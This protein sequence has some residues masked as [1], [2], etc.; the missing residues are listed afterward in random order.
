MAVGLKVYVEPLPQGIWVD[1]TGAEAFDEMY[2]R[3]HRDLVALCRRLLCGR[4]DPEAVAQEAFLRAWLSLDRYSTAR[5][6]WPWLATIARRL[7]IDHR[8]RLQREDTHAETGALDALPPTMSSPEEAIE[9]G[10]ERR[11]AYAA[12][13]RLKP[14]EQ[15]VI[16]LRDLNGWSY[17]EIA[18]FEGVTVE[19]IRGALKRARTSLRRSYASVAGGAP[20]AGVGI[21]L[22]DRVRG[23]VHGLVGR[24]AHLVSP[25]VLTLPS[26]QDV[27][28]G[29]IALVTSVGAVS[30]GA[31]GTQEPQVPVAQVN[32]ATPGSTP[33]AGGGNSSGAAAPADGGPTAAP[34]GPAGPTS[35]LP[36]GL[37]DDG[38]D[39]PEATRVSS[40]TRSP[41]VERD[42]TVFAGATVLGCAYPP[43]AALFR[44]TDAGVTWARLPATGY[45][46]GEV[47][48][49]PSYPS[50][51]RIFVTGPAG[52][53]VSTDDGATFTA[54]APVGGFAAVSPGFSQGD[55]RILISGS[56]LW[57]YRDDTEAAAPAVLAFGPSVSTG[58]IAFDPGSA[59]RRV[60]V[61]GTTMSAGRQVATVFACDGVVCGPGVRLGSVVGAPAV[62]AGDD[63]VLAWR[64]TS[65]F[66]SLDDGATFAEVALPLGGTVSDVRLSP[67][68]DVYV[69]V[70]PSATSTGGGVL[71]SSDDGASWRVLGRGTALA[72]GVTSV[73][74]LHG[75]RLLAAPSVESGAG[76]L[77]SPDGGTTWRPR[78][79]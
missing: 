65:L 61:G 46:G 19:S 12:L 57:E 47:L 10:E 33:A 52:L 53:Q 40:I 73:A 1:G 11:S 5:P 23:R 70:A 74:A 35:R 72:R 15:R 13:R 63:V 50:D 3:C 4:G 16:A 49:P 54:L 36:G 28:V 69:A 43:C 9:E 48:L 24:R 58:G 77:C 31:V 68:G 8:R 39:T 7:C 6:F 76:I 38:G 59:G 27:V 67:S 45:V 32:P 78:C 55:P 25:S 34:K 30:G 37:L 62:A 56:P 66:R 41:H 44:S 60:L 14:A 20:A 18:R 71:V 51:N 75:G 2:R 17:E 22:V 42:G 29:L 64:G 79:R 26:M 21:G